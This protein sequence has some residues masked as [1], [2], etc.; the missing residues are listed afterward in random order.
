MTVND[1]ERKYSHIIVYNTYRE[2]DWWVCTT[3]NTFP[4][5]IINYHGS[6]KTWRIISHNRIIRHSS[7]LPTNE[8]RLMYIIQTGCAH[9][10]TTQTYNDFL[11]ME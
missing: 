9:P 3:P 5:E 10:L 4:R 6:T 7:Q 11:E 8:Q 1:F 2:D